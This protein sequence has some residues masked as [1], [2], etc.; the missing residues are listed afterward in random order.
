M[1]I[2]L[3]LTALLFAGHVFAFTT[4]QIE[5]DSISSQKQSNFSH[6]LTPDLRILTL[7][8][9]QINSGASVKVIACRPTRYTTS[10][11]Y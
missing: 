11:E 9:C 2:T 1:C 8:A 4:F 5:T 6:H 10:S 3:L 7:T